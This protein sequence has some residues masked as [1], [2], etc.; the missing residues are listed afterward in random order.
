MIKAVGL[1]SGGLDSA[2]ACALLQDQGIEVHGVHVS[3]PWGCGS[4]ARTE[5]LTAAMRIPLKVIALGDDY[6][7]LLVKPRYG[8]GAALNPCVECHAYMIQKAAGYM[9]EIG[10][11]LVFTGEV[12]GQRPLSQRRRCME[13]IEQASGVS[14]RLL[15][16]LSAQFFPPTLAEQAGWV[17]RTRLLRLSGRGR[18]EQ[19]KIAAKLGVGAFAQPGG[20]CLLTERIFGSRVKDVLARG[21]NSIREL[22]FLGSGRYFRLD[23][24]TIVMLGRNAR[25]N[26]DLPALAMDNDY[27]LETV[28]FPG[29]TAVLRGRAV[30]GHHLEISAGLIQYFS[31]RRAGEPCQVP[32]RR[33]SPAGESGVAIARILCEEQVSAMQIRETE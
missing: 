3:M 23:E 20:G 16:P 19:K 26:A 31:K 15:R 9:K 12:L 5:A 14:G 30:A 18:T 29:P 24:E 2:V 17:D 6:L 22:A 32:F 27:I 13:W 1:V 28:D 7:P 11:E 4:I 25:E 10:A 33:I 8:F 21:C